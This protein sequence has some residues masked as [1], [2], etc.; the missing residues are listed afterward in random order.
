[1]KLQLNSEK[2]LV[3]VTIFFL[4]LASPVLTIPVI[5]AL[6]YILPSKHINLTFAMLLM[7]MTFGLLASTTQSI[8]TDETDVMRY[9][10]AFGQLVQSDSIE[11]FLFSYIADRGEINVIFQ[12][13]NLILAK[14]F[15]EHARI[16]PFF[17]TSLTYFFVFLS[18]KVLTKTEEGYERKNLAYCCAAAGLGFVFFFETT[19]IIKQTA[20]FSIMGYG[21]CLQLRSRKGAIPLAIVAILIHFSTLMLLP[22]LFVSGRK[23]LSNTILIAMLIVGGIMA[24]LNINQILSLIIGVVASGSTLAQR[25]DLYTDYDGWDPGSRFYLI[26]AFY[27]FLV[28]LQAIIFLMERKRNKQYFVDLDKIMY[29]NITALCLLLANRGNVHNFI[30]YTLT[31]FPF[32][33]FLFYAYLKLRIQYTVRVFICVLIPVF[34]TFFNLSLTYSLTLAQKDYANSYMDNSVSRIVFSNIYDY[35]IYD[36]KY[37]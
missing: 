24:F 21:I 17:W 12:I 26:L 36:V 8:G 6:I 9:Y 3:S 35:L 7:A 30:R 16:L 31:F 33:L 19:E 2:L 14:T 29:V 22:V 4:W 13:V 15:P 34:F 20:A 11:S 28:L 18:V 1:M 27:V 32:Y 25:A 37:E 23:Y 10:W 5:I